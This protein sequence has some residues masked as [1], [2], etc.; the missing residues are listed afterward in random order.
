M[1]DAP[2]TNAA[3]SRAL[4]SFAFLGLLL[5][6]GACKEKAPAEAAPAASED[7]V[8]RTK[9]ASVLYRQAEATAPPEKY[10]AFKRLI[11]IYDDTVPGVNAYLELIV[12]LTR[13]VPPRLDDALKYARS[14][15]DRHPTD[16]RVGESFLQVADT[17]YSVKDDAKRQA[18]LADW[19]AHLE[20]RDIAEDMPKAALR[21]DMVR[22]RLRQERWDDAEVAIDTAL[23]EPTIESSDRVELLVRKGNLLADKLHKKDAARKAFEEALALSRDLH[24]KKTGQRAIAPDQIEA[25]IKKLGS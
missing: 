10:D 5:L 19:S 9:K 21:L 24:S 15:R 7:Q 2:D 18:A 4:A 6:V 12:G 1:I 14:F 22:L 17:A 16:P 25:E 20:A 8:E 13:D 3:R 23:A 11:A